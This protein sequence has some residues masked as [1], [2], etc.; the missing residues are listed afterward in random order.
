MAQFSVAALQPATSYSDPR[1]LRA[2]VRTLHK[3]RRALAVQ[4]PAPDPL[5]YP[6]TSGQY[7]TKVNCVSYA[8]ARPTEGLPPGALSS[9]RDSTSTLLKSLRCDRGVAILINLMRDGFSD[10]T[11]SSWP[12]LVYTRG[13]KYHAVRLASDARWWEKP[14][15]HAV[16]RL[17]VLNWRQLLHATVDGERYD[18][19]AVLFFDPRRAESKT[20]LPRTSLEA[21]L[22]TLVS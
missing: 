13:A 8:A 20:S 14:G 6:V 7:V 9:E 11:G 19:V 21:Q 15:D 2:A 16:R 3:N 12:V 22:W 1:A 4:A 10:P 5:A 17:R 18:L